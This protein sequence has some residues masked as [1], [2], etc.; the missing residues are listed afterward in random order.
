MSKKKKNFRIVSKPSFILT[1]IPSYRGFPKVT[2]SVSAQEVFLRRSCNRT[3]R[4]GRSDYRNR[5]SIQ[6]CGNSRL[7]P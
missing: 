1:P 4:R 2:I 7:W 3:H 5:T 6:K